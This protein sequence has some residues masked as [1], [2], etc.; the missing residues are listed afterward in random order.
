MNRQQTEQS[1]TLALRDL[2]DIELEILNEIVSR[3]SM[4]QRQYGAFQRDDSR[5]WRKEAFEEVLDTAIYSARV[6]VK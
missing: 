1:I 4:G 2:G 5:D 3:I 6:L